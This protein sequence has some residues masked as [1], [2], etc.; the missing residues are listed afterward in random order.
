MNWFNCYTLSLLHS[1]DVSKKGLQVQ[2]KPAKLCVIS[3]NWC[4]DSFYRQTRLGQEFERSI[5][6]VL[7]CLTL[8]MDVAFDVMF[9]I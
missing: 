3:S 9:F 7:F 4:F 5:I 1:L 2:G 6:F 8:C